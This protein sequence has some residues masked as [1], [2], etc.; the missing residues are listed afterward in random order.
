M[1]ASANVTIAFTV[2]SDSRFAFLADELGCDIDTA[3]GRMARLWSECTDLETDTPHPAV[4]C[5]CLKSAHAV[6]ALIKANLAAEEGDS[7]RIKGCRERINWLKKRREAAKAGGQRSA[8]Q[9]SS[10]AQAHAKPSAQAPAQRL[11]EQ[12]QPSA[13]PGAHPSGTQVLRDSGIQVSSNP[14]TQELSL[15]Q[16]KRSQRLSQDW[17]PSEAHRQ[18]ATKL[19][20]S[21]DTQAAMF[22]D[23]YLANGKT[24]ADWNAAFNNWLRR[25]GDYAPRNAGKPRD[26]RVGRI[27]PD[28]S[29]F[30]DMEGGDVQL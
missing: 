17:V 25:A 3:I 5:G 7:V 13:Q 11:L 20:L 15:V 21:A 10:A 28:P 23:H 24:M 16:R 26:V 2:W 27:D 19:S 18:L 6:K 29:K 9:R 30:D 14:G 4:V 22:R 12:N 1:A 8:E